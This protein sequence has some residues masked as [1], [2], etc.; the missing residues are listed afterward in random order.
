MKRE[1]KVIQ[2]PVTEQYLFNFP[3][4]ENGVNLGNLPESQYIGNLR[5]YGS[6]SATPS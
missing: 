4:T 6:T 3:L 1:H 2:T 5:N